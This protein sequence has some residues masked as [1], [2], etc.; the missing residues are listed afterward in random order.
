MTRIRTSMSGQFASPRNAEDEVRGRQLRRVALM[1]DALAAISL[2][3]VVDPDLRARIHAEAL[4]QLDPDGAPPSPAVTAL[5]A[6][7]RAE[8]LFEP[9][10]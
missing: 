3:R 9:K 7:R 10:G 5:E 8:A 1:R 2:P 6:K 4:R